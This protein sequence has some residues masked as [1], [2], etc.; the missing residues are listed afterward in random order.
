MKK[1]LL[2]LLLA[3]LLCG[4]TPEAEP[5][6]DTLPAAA[7][8]QPT[9][10]NGFYDPG[11][12]IEA[13]TG[14]AVRCYPLGSTGEASLLSLGDD[15]LLI[16]YEEA[17]TTLTVLTGDTLHPTAHLALGFPL[18]PDAPS[19][20]R[21][22]SGISLC[23][24]QTKETV[25]LDCALREVAR[26]PAP[27]DL[28]GNPL[29]CADR[30][31]LYYCTSDAVRALDLESGIS[32]C[33]KEIAYPAQEITG[34]WLEDTVV[35]CTISDADGTQQ[36]LFLS[37][38]NGQIL[39]IAP[40]GLTLATFGSRYYA[41]FPNGSVNSLVFGTGEEPASALTPPEP[42]TG[43]HFLPE[44]HAA[45][46]IRQ[47]KEAAIVLDYYD[48]D[49]GIRSSVLTLETSHIPQ[50][51]ETNPEGKVFF[52]NYDEDYGCNTLCLWDP[53]ALP[54]QDNTIYTAPHFTLSA[55]DYEGLAACSL[56][57]QEISQRYGIR[58]LVYKDAIDI[59]PWDYD[60]E[61]EHLAPVI[62]KELEQLDARLGNYPEGFLQ[63]L[64]QRFDGLTLCIVRSI[65][66]TAESGS[67]D[68]AKGVQ[69]WEGHHA[70]IALAA[71][72]ETEYTLY[73]ELCH[74]ID[75]VVLGESSAYDRWDELNPSGF[76]YDYDYTANRSRNSS[77]Y[78]REGSRYFIDMYSMSFPKEDRARIM[79][80]AMTE[81][82]AACFQS[83][84]M[85][86]KLKLLCQGIREAFGLRKSPETFLW[87]QYLNESLAYTK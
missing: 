36:T 45:V 12:P 63:T 74:L 34:A 44:G 55:P 29:L 67:L 73:H 52:L 48:L 65:S 56:Y 61:V 64:S 11:S 8:P 81:G 57:A 77:E 66:G 42:V 85:Q 28:Q 75:T 54:S 3:L 25:V 71:G 84:A 15:L 14:G 82:N 21:W 79:E 19:F 50:D 72:A 47:T 18:T 26:I 87:E 31:T 69:F 35:E 24:P 17:E 58:V 78:L 49:T 22:D 83:K 41:A 76:E 9:E 20:R 70:Y 32:R 40:K 13:R 27:K 43:C 30:S 5:A 62:R 10:P 1:C 60:L 51:F 33:L 53:A 39:D 4:C 37:A 6:A 59:Q 38:E 2:I 86:A 46:A 68:A 23:H 7:Q 16:R 80:Y